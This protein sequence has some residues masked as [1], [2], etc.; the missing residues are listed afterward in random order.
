MKTRQPKNYGIQQNCSKSEVYSNTNLPQETCNISYK[1]PN[2]TPKEI[3]ERRIETPH[4]DKKERY[5]DQ[6]RNK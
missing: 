4:H 1:Q 3:R 5:K 2:L 6:I